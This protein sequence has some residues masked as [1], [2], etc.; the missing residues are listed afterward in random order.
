ML[1][2][3]PA[4]LLQSATLGG[5]VGFRELLV[6]EIM[7]FWDEQSGGLFGTEAA[8]AAGAGEID[9][10]STTQACAALCLAG[11]TAEGARLGAFLKFLIRSQPDAERRFLTTWNS[12]T[13]AWVKD[14]APRRARDEALEWNAPAQYLY[15][16]GLL[17]RALALLH[18]ASG[19]PECLFLAEEHFHLATRGEWW[20]NTLAHKMAWASAALHDATGKREY[21]EA[22]CRVAEHLVE[23][24]QPEG[25]FHYP[26]YWPPP[27][28]VSFEQKA[29]IGCQFAAWIALAKDMATEVDLATEFTEITEERPQS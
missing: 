19:D 11:R 2:Y 3:L 18:Q 21:A 13:K 26:E 15:K 5:R 4:W 9:F 17:I 6:R 24:Q 10:D 25:W 22:A 14:T 12:A 1:P 16:S 29:G 27:E 23:L 8:R 7:G 28:K 20:N